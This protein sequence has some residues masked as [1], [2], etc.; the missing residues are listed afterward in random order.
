[1]GVCT[2]LYVCHEIFIS[3][4]FC[5]LN[6]TPHRLTQPGVSKPEYLYQSDNIKKSKKIPA[7]IIFI[8]IKSYKNVNRKAL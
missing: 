2:T 6:L 5:F 1:M 8:C 3:T 4:D 7:S